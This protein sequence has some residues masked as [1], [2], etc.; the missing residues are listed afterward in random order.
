[1]QAMTATQRRVVGGLVRVAG[2]ERA[3]ERAVV[4][5]QQK[6]GRTATAKQLL[7]HILEFR[8]QQVQHRRSEISRARR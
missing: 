1:M 7:R 4:E 6:H 2:G 5:Y 3:L 8:K